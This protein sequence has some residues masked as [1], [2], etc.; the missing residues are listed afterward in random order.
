MRHG[1]KPTVRQAKLISKMG[2][3]YENWL[4][5]KNTSNELVIVHRTTGKP[6]VLPKSLG[7]I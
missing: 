1:K 2:L 7:G 3:N 6:R 5:I 4:V